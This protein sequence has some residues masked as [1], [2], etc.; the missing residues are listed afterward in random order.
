MVEIWQKKCNNFIY[1]RARG[2]GGMNLGPSGFNNFNSG[3]F[4][5][6][7]DNSM[8][9]GRGGKGF[10]M[11]GGSGGGGGRPMG[12]GGMN[13]RM[14]PQNSKTGHSVHMRGL[15]FDA[16]ADDVLKFFAPLSPVDI[17]IL[18]EPNGRPKGKA[19]L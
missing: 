6:N 2:R 9:S 3:N 11:R 18:K 13:N 17:R 4:G 7:Y 14:I 10:P 5:S 8:R 15:P 16:N 12:G 1:F 19:I